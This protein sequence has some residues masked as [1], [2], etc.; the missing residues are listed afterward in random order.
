M[1]LGFGVARWPQHPQTFYNPTPTSNPGRE[2]KLGHSLPRVGERVEKCIKVR[3]PY[4]DGEHLCFLTCDAL[5]VGLTSLGWPCCD[6][7]GVVHF[8]EY[9]FGQSFEIQTDHQP[10]MLLMSTSKL[11]GKFARWALTL[12]EY[13]FESVHRPRMAN[14][15]ADGCSGC[16]LPRGEGDEDAVGEMDKGAFYNG[17]P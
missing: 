7:S 1:G 16:P 9:L 8:E 4:S 3:F 13:D 12:Q 14:A 15:N 5:P 10:L 11:T 17:E 6:W 2:L